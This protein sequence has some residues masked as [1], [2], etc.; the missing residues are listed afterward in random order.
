M[1][2]YTPIDMTSLIDNLTSTY[3]DLMSDTIKSDEEKKH[4]FSYLID[5]ISIDIII[6]PFYDKADIL[7]RIN[8]ITNKAY[9]YP[10]NI[11][12]RK[13]FKEYIDDKYKEIGTIN[14][15]KPT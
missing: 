8:N 12:Y 14:P 9:T 11:Y 13:D 15:L 7:Q 4:A 6:P 2:F 1:A 3:E 10:I 5:S